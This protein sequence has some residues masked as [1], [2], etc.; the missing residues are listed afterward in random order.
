MANK[1]Q[2]GKK[3]TPGS[4]QKKAKEAES[5]TASRQPKKKSGKAEEK[6]AAKEKSGSLAG[7]GDSGRPQPAAAPA[8]KLSR[9]ISYD[10]MTPEIKALFDAKYPDGY[11]DFVTRYPKPSGES[12]YAVSLYTDQAD[13]LI[14]VDVDVDMALDVDYDVDETSSDEEVGS[15]SLGDERGGPD[16]NDLAD[17]LA[18]EVSDPS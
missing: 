11:A 4:A 3:K 5:P 13:Y 9:I 17:S 8:K 6:S 2:D 18:D 7:S 12:F 14:K 16:V 10:K 15:E 1:T